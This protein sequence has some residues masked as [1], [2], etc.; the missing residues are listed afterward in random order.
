MGADERSYREVAEQVVD[1]ILGDLR[2]RS[3]LDGAWDS[4]D[5]DTQDEI[6]EEWKKLVLVCMGCEV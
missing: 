1:A 6:R 3:G 5:G 4:I 2:G